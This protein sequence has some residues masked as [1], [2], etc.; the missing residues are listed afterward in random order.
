MICYGQH[1]AITFVT[2]ATAHCFFIFAA[3]TVVNGASDAP[4]SSTLRT[5]TVPPTSTVRHIVWA[6]HVHALRLIT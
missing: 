4:R 2:S 6:T 3:V 1:T 5:M